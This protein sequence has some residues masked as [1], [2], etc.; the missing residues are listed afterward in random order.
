MQESLRRGSIMKRLASACNLQKLLAVPSCVYACWLWCLWGAEE[1]ELCARVRRTPPQ[2]SY[3]KHNP[4]R[5][6]DAEACMTLK[7]CLC[8]AQ[9][10]NARTPC[11]HTLDCPAPS[12]SAACP[13]RVHGAIAATRDTFQPSAHRL[14][15][16]ASSRATHEH[17][18]S[19]VLAY[20]ALSLSMHAQAASPVLP[21]AEPAVCAAAC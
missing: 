21:P 19:V 2:C 13:L 12:L 18:G 14:T 9:T 6:P 10:T 4:V 3:T 1:V 8:E 7:K 11:R 16:A 20:F 15:C 17:I 5:N